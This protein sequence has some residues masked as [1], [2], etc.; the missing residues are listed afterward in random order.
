[1]VYIHGGSFSS[2]SAMVYDFYGVPL[3]AVGDVIVVVLNYRLGVF[4]K[5][6]TSK[7]SATSP[8]RHQS[9]PTPHLP[10]NTHTDQTI[11][12]NGKESIG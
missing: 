1:M 9:H 10:H 8:N 3:V 4:A 11:V 12:L 6:T 5:F 7:S 2:G